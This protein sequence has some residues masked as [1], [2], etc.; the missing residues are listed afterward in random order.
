[1]GNVDNLPFDILPFIFQHLYRSDLV[2][3]ALVSRTFASG[4]LPK[5]YEYIIIRLSFIKR[6]DNVRC[7]GRVSLRD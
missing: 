1:M 7:S 6:I 5:L 4:A 3:S 2:A